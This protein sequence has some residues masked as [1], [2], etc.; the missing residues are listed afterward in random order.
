M[1]QRIHW[2]FTSVHSQERL[3]LQKERASLVGI[4]QNG[5][6]T[7]V[8]IQNVKLLSPAISNYG[9]ECLWKFKTQ[10]L[11]QRAPLAFADLDASSSGH[12]LVMS[13]LPTSG[14][15]KPS[16]CAHMKFNCKCLS[17]VRLDPVYSLLTAREVAIVWEFFKMLD[18]R[19]EMALDGK[20]QR[21]TELTQK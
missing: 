19:N 16:S 5:A 14:Y 6:T 21:M 15:S 2:L 11:I 4:Q 12:I 13:L 17:H 8:L 3:L 18:V 9:K 10:R 20:M 7:S 1:S